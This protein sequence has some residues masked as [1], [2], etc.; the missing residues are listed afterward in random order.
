MTNTPLTLLTAALLL[1]AASTASAQDAPEP[2][3][4]GVDVVNEAASGDVSAY[5]P[6]YTGAFVGFGVI[7]GSGRLTQGVQD[8]WGSTFGLL[9][10]Y[11][12]PL[13]FFDLQ[14]SWLHSRHTSSFDD[15]TAV[16]MNTDSLTLG[17]GIH[18]LFLLHLESNLVGYILGGAYL[19]AGIDAEFIRGSID[20][21]EDPDDALDLHY[22]IGGGLD[23][24]L[25]DV[26]DGGSFWL[27]L[28]YR[29]NQWTFEKSPIG[30]VEQHA[31]MMRLTYR[32][33]GLL[34]AL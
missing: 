9:A 30:E 17:L 1:A 23:V 6:Y 29:F 20:G 11:S 32:R 18:P 12:L 21:A 34:L 8:D 22:V 16:S 3:R 31:I 28:Q 27:G 13:Q 4:S 5:S 15:G 24:P 14:A 7:A 33:N 19:L 2:R 10:Q 26:N 25:D